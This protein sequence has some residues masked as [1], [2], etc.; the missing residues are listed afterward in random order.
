MEEQSPSLKQSPRLI[1]GKIKD[2]YIIK[3]NK[4]LLN[5]RKI[6]SNHWKKYYIFNNIKNLDNIKKP[7]ERGLAFQ[8]PLREIS[9]QKVIIP[10]DNPLKMTSGIPSK[11]N[12]EHFFGNPRDFKKVISSFVLN[13]LKDD[14]WYS[15]MCV[16]VLCQNINSNSHLFCVHIYCNLRKP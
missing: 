16:N 14:Q 15:I 8:T 6:E 11:G 7:L 9:I 13:M 1:G 2:V 5:T 12:P 3:T 4:Y 10:S